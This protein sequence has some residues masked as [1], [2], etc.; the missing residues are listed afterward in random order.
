MTLVST[1]LA[2]ARASS[3][4]MVY[5]LSHEFERNANALDPIVTIAAGGSL[6]RLEAGP[7]SDIDCIIVHRSGVEPKHIAAAMDSIAQ[8]FATS[9][10]K[11]PKIDGI[12]RTPVNADALL[13]RAALGSLDETPAVFGKRMQLLL[14]ARPLFGGNAFNTL[15]AAVVDWYCSDFVIAD[16]SASWTYLLNDLTR[17]LHAYAGWQQFKFARTN[18]DSWALRQ[19]KFRS[20]RLIT[21]A[22]LLFLLG[23]SN[24][25]AHKREW[26]KA[27]LALTP[28]ERLALVMNKYDGAA[29]TRLEQTYARVYSLLVDPKIRAQLLRT[30]PDVGQR[31]GGPVSSEFEQIRAE[32]DQILQILTRFALD[33][34]DD[35]D[36][37]FFARWLF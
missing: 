34:C 29:Y 22:G 13:D 35:W 26:L 14:D 19:A 20:S 11:A 4:E 18:D 9:P 1:T 27:Q 36:P 28:L 12:Y 5:A 37:R 24:R 16:P 33:R 23:E 10:L 30:G 15:Q 31:L 17:Y 25:S 8:V 7:A 21:F 6:G 3:L 2:T 32:T